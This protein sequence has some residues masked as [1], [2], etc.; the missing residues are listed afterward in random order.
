MSDKQNELQPADNIPSESLSRAERIK[1]IKNSIRSGEQ[2]T[3]SP[4]TNANVPDNQTSAAD[5]AEEDWENEIAERIAK[6][7]QKMKADKAAASD[8]NSVDAENKENFDA[9]LEKKREI[10]PADETPQISEET[11]AE[12]P[13]TVSEDSGE[14][15]ELSKEKIPAKKKSA[16]KKK[17]KK[18]K[19]KSFKDSVLDL[20]PQKK[21]KMSERVRKVVFLGSCAAIIICGTMVISYYVDTIH[22]QGVYDDIENVYL[23]YDDIVPETV[24]DAPSEE[25]EIYTMFTWAEKL[26]AQNNDLVGYITIPGSISD[27]EAENE[28]AY[29]VVQSDDLEKY[30]DTNFYGETARAGTLFLDYRNKFDSVFEGKLIAPNSDNLIIYGHNMQDGNMFGKLK[31]YRNNADYYGEHP[32]I[33][34]DSKYKQYQYK[35]FAFFIIDASD[36]TD[37]AFDCWNSINFANETEFYD[38]VNEAKRRTIRL[39]DVDVKY[40]DKLLTLST[41]N[42]IFGNDG[43]GR[44]IVMARLVREGEDLYEGTQNSTENPNIKWPSLYYESNKNAKYDPDAEFVPYGETVPE[45]TTNTEE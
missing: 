41:C 5:Y 13:M 18:K 24:T 3:E 29:P 38:Y 11:A 10:Q 40:G 43:P 27:P 23:D 2:Q 17:S 33:N 37:T 9:E 4:E 39:N 19:K 8:K 6:R 45:E 15:N 28:I 42:S 21:D 22:T 36:K 1:A 30:L 12:Q 25:E 16:K 7:V 31:N 14:N 35:I 26:M 20:L 34:L 44:L 32:I